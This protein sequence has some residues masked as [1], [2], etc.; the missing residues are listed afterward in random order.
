MNTH[1][2]EQF[3]NLVAEKVLQEN[4]SLFLGAGSSMQ[5]DAMNWNELINKVYAGA[6]EWGNTERAQYAELTGINI[7]SAVSK[8]IS[9]VNINSKKTDTYLAHLLGFNIKSIWTTNYDSVIERVLEKKGQTYIPVFMY[10]HFRKLSYPGGKFLFKINGSH[11]SPET[12]VITREDFIEYRKSHEAYLILLKRELLCQSFLFLG[13]SFDDDI[14][15][16]CIK[17]IL[18][19]IDN[20][21]ENY[22]TDHYAIIATSNQDKLDFTSK[23]LVTYYNINCLQV[24]T[25]SN[26]SIATSLISQRVKYNSIFVSGAR[27][28][29]RH[30]AE[31]EMGK[32]ICHNLI[33]A[34]MSI[35]HF[36][37][38]FISGMGMSIGHFITGAVKNQCEG[39]NQNRYLQME[40]FPF[41]SQS[42]NDQHRKDIMSRAGIFIFIFGD[43]GD[44]DVNRSGMWREYNQATE[45]TLSIIIPL[46][47][48]TDSVSNYIFENELLNVNSFTYSNKD[49]LCS[50]D[51]T[52]ANEQFFADLVSKVILITRMKMDTLLREA[53]SKF[54]AA[55]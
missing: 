32:I 3:T 40:P 13:C 55:D 31:E 39:R 22:S 20:S 19:C 43:I 7:K 21:T 5:Y 16:I 48:G 2:L 25:P 45:D 24:Q 1:D 27:A 9:S 28:F 41:T 4:L 11:E 33:K 6:T 29:Q 46:P 49:L 53:Q 12:I 30:S 23:D 44:K 8:I 35:E 10:N 18:H 52:K 42:D 38:K 47:C 14:L 51:H 26:A 34:F 15:R 36:P 54:T 17:D 37:F 50:Y